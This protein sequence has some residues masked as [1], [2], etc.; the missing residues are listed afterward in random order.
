MTLASTHQ[1]RSR[2]DFVPWIVAFL[3]IPCLVGAQ[4]QSAEQKEEPIPFKV[5]S[6]RQVPLP[7]QQRKLVIQRVA[8]PVLPSPPAVEP[9]EPMDPVILEQ[10]RAAWRALAPLETRLLS[11][12]AIVYEN[13]WTFLTWW[14]HD[15]KGQFQTFE[16]WSQTDLRSLWMVSDFEVN[17]VRYM[18]FPMVL[19]ASW[20]Y[21]GSRRHPLPGPLSFEGTPGYR[22]VKGD[23]SNT[24]A[25]NPITALHEIYRKEGDLLAA[26]WGEVQKQ[27][28][29]DEEWRKANPPVPQDT[30]IRMWPKK[31]RRH[32]ADGPQTQHSNAPAR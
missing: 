11:V 16:A 19:D 18:I 3:S 30:I 15:E 20:K 14:H 5:L 13:G 6:E 21:S 9:K 23:A 12:T 26:Q 1:I 8:P 17:R 25:L 10:R 2:S 4:I 32:A 22:L 27:R 28:Q 24:K 31:S 29:A 7:E